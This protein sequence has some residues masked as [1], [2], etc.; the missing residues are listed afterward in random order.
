MNEVGRG[1]NSSG[2]G[3]VRLHLYLLRSEGRHPTVLPVRGQGLLW[4][5]EKGGQGVI[6]Q[7]LEFHLEP[8][9]HLNEKSNFDFSEVH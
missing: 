1:K 7:I 8:N 3:P 4:E 9:L 6:K 5:W 2:M